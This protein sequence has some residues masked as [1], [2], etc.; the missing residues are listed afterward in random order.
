MSLTAT[1]L[2]H[3]T[4]IIRDE[5]RE[6]V[7]AELSTQLWPLTHACANVE[8]PLLRDVRRT[9]LEAVEND[10]K[11]IYLMHVQKDTADQ[12]DVVLPEMDRLKL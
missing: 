9:A 11:E 10:I 8:I 4:R 5:I 1:D 12:E 7:R 3:I 2:Q 6:E